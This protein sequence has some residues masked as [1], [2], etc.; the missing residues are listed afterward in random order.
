MK[1][2][3]KTIKVK[4]KDGVAVLTMD[5][6]PVNQLSPNFATELAE[7]IGEAFKDDE[8][9]AVVL[10]GTGKNFVAGA[11]ITQI[12]GIKNKNDVF[13]KALMM[14]QFISS[15]ETGTK[16][17]IAAINGNALGGGLEISM[18]CHYR[19]AAKGIDLGQPEVKI[20]LI[21]GAG[22]TQRLPR[23]IGLPN[24]LEMITVGNPIKAEKAW[25]RGLVDEVV[26]PDKLIE[27][28]L[29]AAKKFISRQLN[30]KTRMTR[31]M[32]A[33]LPSTAEK[34][35]LLGFTKAMTAQKAKGYIAPF[36]AIEA[37]EKGLSYDI[38]ADIE[39]EVD[40][41]SD[42]A[43]SDVADNLIGIFLNTRSAGRLPRIEGIKSATKLYN[44]LYV[45]WSAW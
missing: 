2:D 42:C 39:R 31:N 41:F 21:P 37:V 33:R 23:L 20:G 29:K 3:Y 1:T 12:Q 9:Q 11:D 19:V 7:S 38:D 17:V 8:V 34:K 10:T 4:L 40:L 28:A 22:G 15:I 18:G 16:P 43:I 5:N 6:P 35:A 44:A 30:L 32:N 27:T 45:G 26:D 13:P 25:S 36:K 24:A 14:A